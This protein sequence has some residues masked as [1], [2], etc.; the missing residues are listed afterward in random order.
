ML[1][2]GERVVGDRGQ[3]MRERDAVR[4][5]KDRDSAAG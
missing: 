4:D 3:C 2:I 1:G 5:M